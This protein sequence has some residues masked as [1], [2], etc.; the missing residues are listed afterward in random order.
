MLVYAII[1]RFVRVL[2]QVIKA[3]TLNDSLKLLV[4]CSV[5]EI[6]EARA[7]TLLHVKIF[8]SSRKILRLP[9]ICMFRCGKPNF[10]CFSRG[11][12]RNYS[13]GC[14]NLRLRNKRCCYAQTLNIGHNEMKVCN[15]LKSLDALILTFCYSLIRTRKVGYSFLCQFNVICS[16]SPIIYT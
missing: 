3:H 4:L 13:E 7:L 10:T 1:I 8:R 14:S 2:R 5:F 6:P 16:F 15:K 12:S 9:L 11:G